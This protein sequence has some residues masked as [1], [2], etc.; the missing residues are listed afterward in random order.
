MGSTATHCP[1]CALQCGI[2]LQAQP[3]SEHEP[4]ALSGRDFETNGGALCRKGYSAARLLAHPERLQSP[5]LR[6]PDG[7][8]APIG[9]EQA[10]D[11]VARQVRD[12]RTAHG[13][14]AVAV[15][16]AGGLTNEKAYQ[17]GKFARLALG[18]SR[19]DYNGRFCMS[20][21]AAGANRAFGLDRGLPFPLADLDR[22]AMILMLGSNVADTM[23]PFVRHLEGAR[24]SGGLVVVD[25]RRSATAK[26]CD[27][28]GWHLQPTPATD[29]Q[30]L[31]GLCH[32]LLAESL[33]D[34]DYLARRTTGLAQLRSSVAAWWPERTEAVTG[35][36]ASQIRRTARE[37]AAAAQ[38]A[39]S[40]AD[41]V[42]I[43][44]GRGVEQHENG[45]DTVTAAINLALLLGLPG[46]R[47]GGYG[48]ITGQGNGQG[49]REHG[50]KCDQLPGYRKITDPEHR[51]HVARVWGVD[52]EVI[53]GP[54]VPATELLH[55][56]GTDDGARMLLVHGSNP[57]LSSPDASQVIAGLRRLDFLVVADFFLSETAAEAHLVLPVLQWAEEEGTMTNL[58]G[59]VLRRRAALQPPPQARDELWIFAELARRLDAPGTFSSDPR[60]VF[61]ELRRASAG[62]LA[63]YS[64]ID[65][66]DLDAGAA[67]YWPCPRGTRITGTR[68]G[69]PRL[70]LNRFAHPDGKARLTAVHATAQI[71][72]PGRLSL[73]T[74]RLL[75]HYQ[76]GTQTRRVEELAAA[77][78]EARLEIHPA[79]ALAYGIA[80]GQRVQLDNERGRVIARAALSTDIRLDTVFLPFHFPGGNNANVLTET[81]VDPSSA[82]PE[83]KHTTVSL[84]PLEER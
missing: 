68:S 73:V 22:A 11:L 34:A 79:T 64:G 29:L 59:R 52:P 83:F 57:A 56:L 61:E 55:T 28:S 31:L 40:G 36:P 46:T 8:F 78:P 21:A 35:V 3:A 75:E 19:I 20:S 51:A 42:Y 1:Y 60:E 12:T 33:V 72:R 80:E 43:L 47:A 2:S 50:Q 58:E 13:A 71:H 41:P 45:T 4:L 26:L 37:L 14:D 38:A 9:W 27:G 6:Q 53:P 5:L 49:G 18:T 74:G 63:D 65:W 62:G 23:P 30:L 15:F 44:T 67:V 81:L 25:P 17:L 70:F 7:S 84:H 66:E 32:V 16:G 76:S 82:M 24:A 39:R 48:T 10:L 77:A 54:G 69:T